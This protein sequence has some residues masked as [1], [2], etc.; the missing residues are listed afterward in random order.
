MEQLYVLQCE[1]GK[2]YVGKTADVMRRFDE[3]KSGKGSAWTRKYKPVRLMECRPVSSDHDENNVTKDLMKKYGI[4]NV[5]GGN[6]TQIILPEEYAN[7][8]KLEFRGNADTCYK[9]NLTGHFSNRCPNDCPVPKQKKVHQIVEFE[10]SYCDRTFTTKFGCSVHE[11]SCSNA[12]DEEP[13]HY[14]CY[15][16]GRPGHKS[17]DCYARTHVDGYPL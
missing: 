17:P 9:C 12:V 3:H 5:R 14:V 10:C 8:L 16:C 4:E 6:Y 1:S 15:T 13:V 2:Y 7:V 11:R